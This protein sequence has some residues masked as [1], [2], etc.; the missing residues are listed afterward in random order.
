MDR[1]QVQLLYWNKTAVENFNLAQSMGNRNRF[2][3]G[4]LEVPHP[5]DQLQSNRTMH[6][7]Y[8]LAIFCRQS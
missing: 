1:K 3:S 7:P 6:Q 5:L 8:L 2:L 4:L